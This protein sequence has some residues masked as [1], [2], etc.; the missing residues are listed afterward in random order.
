MNSARQDAHAARQPYE[1]KWERY[2]KLYRSYIKKNPKDWRSKVFM[3]EVFQTIETILPRLVAQ[4]PKFV[5]N[6]QGP[7]DVEAAKKMDTLLAWAADN[8]ELYVHLIDVFK[9]AL[10]YGTGILKTMVKPIYA[11]GRREIPQFSDVVIPYTEPLIDPETMQ[12]LRDPDGNIVLEEKELVK[13]IPAPPI[14]ERYRYT[15]YEGP[16]AQCIDLWNFWIA[17]EAEDVQGADYCIH[18]TFKRWED[19][20][21]LIGDGTYFL[22]DDF[23]E[24]RFFDQSENMPHMKRQQSIDLGSP[25][26]NRQRK[27]IQIEEFWINDGDGNPGRVVTV[28][29]ENLILRVQENPFDHGEKPFVRFVDYKQAHEFWGVGEIEAIEGLQDLENA[30]INQRVDN[31]RLS[32]DKAWAVNT[33]QLEDMRDL[34]RRPGQVIRVKGDGMRPDDVVKAIEFGDVTSS[35]FAE[36]EQTQRMI[37]RVTSVSGLQQGLDT[38]SLTDTATGMAMLSEAGASRFAHKVRQAEIM[39]LKRVGYHYGSLLQQFT[40]EERQIRLTEPDGS[41]R[42]EAFDPM[43]LHGKFDYTIEPSSL[44]QS[45]TVRREQALNLLREVAPLIAGNIDPN[46]GQPLPLHPGL[47]ALLADLLESFGKKDAAKY[48]D[49]Q[50]QPQLPM[51]PEQ[52]AMEQMMDPNAM[53]EVIPMPNG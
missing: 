42:F 39:A 47:K 32:M 15:T 33:S 34:V 22:P 13:Q 11:Y 29:N 46:T 44:L 1:E 2:Y 9:D 43:S 14:S 40:T 12:P 7:E 26:M 36:A 37:E 53:G 45:E 19:V 5:V 30:I 38:P 35:A 10:M 31:V 24:E 28:A 8:S 52:M 51:A 3:P 48:L 4:L 6:P 20:R 27:K 41:T 25:S 16:M 18:R 49:V 23:D 21:K 17:P 50:T